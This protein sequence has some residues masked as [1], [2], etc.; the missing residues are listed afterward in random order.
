M[1]NNYDTNLIKMGL[2]IQ[3]Y[4]KLKGLS[5]EQLSEKVGI[6]LGFLAQIEAPNIVC[7][8]SL[9]TLFEI[10]DALGVA[11]HKFINFEDE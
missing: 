2:K 4:R 10:G 7:G 5:Q 6:S 8:V 1:K 3:Y 9:K 11:P